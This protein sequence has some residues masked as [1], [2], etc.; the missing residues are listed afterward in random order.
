MVINASYFAKH[1]QDALYANVI[2]RGLGNS[3]RKILKNRFSEIEFE[4]ISWSQSCM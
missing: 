1:N 3:P 2:N 4:D